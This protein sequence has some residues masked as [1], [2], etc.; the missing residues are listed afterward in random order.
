MLEAFDHDVRVLR[1]LLRMIDNYLR[2][3]AL[4]YGV[5]EGQRRMAVTAVSAL[6]SALGPDL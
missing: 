2:N 6:D 3:R 5:Q 4:V 1:Y